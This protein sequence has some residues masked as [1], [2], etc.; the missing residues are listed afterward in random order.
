VKRVPLDKPPAALLAVFLGIEGESGVL[1]RCEISPD[2]AGVAAFLLG[3][4]GHSAAMFSGLTGPQNAPL[5]GWLI[6]PHAILT[7]RFG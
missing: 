6:P 2:G 3:A 4:L 5:S 7:F 1:D